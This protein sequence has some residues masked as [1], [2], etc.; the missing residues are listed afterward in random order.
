MWRYSIPFGITVSLSLALN[1]A[2]AQNAPRP[3]TAQPQNSQRVWRNADLAQADTA[4]PTGNVWTNQKID[5]LRTKDPL[6]LVGPPPATESAQTSQGGAATR[7]SG[8]NH[9]EDPRWYEDQA[10]ALQAQIDT[11]KAALDKA[12][13]HLNAALNLREPF[14][15]IQIEGF[16]VLAGWPL[17]VASWGITPD[18]GIANLE[19]QMR[20]L[21]IRKDQLLDL[22]RTNGIDSG[23]LRLAD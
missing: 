9:F 18:E 1:L 5:E 7:E 19:A 20:G 17:G 12:Q 10:V 2:G 21:Q 15:A 6:S 11:T 14:G 3:N 22:A 8:Y 16:N 23:V 13:E 4:S